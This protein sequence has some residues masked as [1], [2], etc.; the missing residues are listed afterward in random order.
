MKNQKP[1]TRHRSLSLRNMSTAFVVLGIGVGLAGI[2]AV[3]HFAPTLTASVGGLAGMGDAG[4]P[5][6]MPGGGQGPGRPVFGNTFD[7]ALNATLSPLVL[8][9]ALALSLLGGLIAGMY[10]GWRA[11]RLSP[12]ESLRSVA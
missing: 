10:G 2:A 12:A 7:V 6:G 5:P 1:D 8:F 3:N 4:G 11:S 9:T